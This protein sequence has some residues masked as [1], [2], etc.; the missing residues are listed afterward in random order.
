MV[1]FCVFIV[2][3]IVSCIFV[4]I[5]VAGAKGLLAAALKETESADK[6]ES[7]LGMKLPDEF[8]YCHR[9]YDKEV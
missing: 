7:R 9:R 3:I 1:V 5:T 2:I 4:V 6:G 8:V